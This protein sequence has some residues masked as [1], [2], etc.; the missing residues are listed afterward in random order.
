[1]NAQE[2]AS[3]NTVLE[4]NNPDTV[5]LNI[6]LKGSWR[7]QDRLPPVETITR[8]LLAESQIG[9]ISFSSNEIA[10]WDSGLLVFLSKLMR[11]C[12]E[13]KLQVMTDGLPAGIRK[14]LDLAAS[15]TDTKDV[16][17]SSSNESLLSHISGHYV[18]SIQ[19]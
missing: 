5:T 16:S 18:V 12:H 2:N 15:S 3:Y 4:L 19:Q 8:K 13:N 6:V 11:S 14:L 7:L 10:N 1:M 17:R 9:R